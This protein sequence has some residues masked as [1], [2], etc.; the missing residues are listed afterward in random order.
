MSKRD[1]QDVRTKSHTCCDQ[2][3]NDNRLAGETRPNATNAHQDHEGF[4]GGCCAGSEIKPTA[5][6]RPK[7]G[8]CGCH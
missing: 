8:G 6:P 3:D 2:G 1:I 5:I 4:P 7:S